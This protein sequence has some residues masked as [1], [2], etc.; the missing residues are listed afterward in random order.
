[1]TATLT[2]SE[3]KIFDLLDDIESWVPD[4]Y[5]LEIDH[6]YEPVA[7]WYAYKYSED[8]GEATPLDGYEDV[9]ITD[10]EVDK[11]KINIIRVL[12]EYGCYYVA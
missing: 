5:E 8:A 10:E 11:E 12:G 7:G 2:K 6:W 3:Q 1:M 9:L 4:G